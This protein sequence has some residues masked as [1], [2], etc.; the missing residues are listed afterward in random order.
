M[1][2]LVFIV[3]LTKVVG[4]SKFQVGYYSCRNIKRLQFTEPI[5]PDDGPWTNWKVSS[6]EGDL[7]CFQK[8]G[9]VPD[10]APMSDPREVYY[11]YDGEDIGEVGLVF[12]K[13]PFLVDFT[14][15]ILLLVLA[16]LQNFLWGWLSNSPEL[17]EGGR[18]TLHYSQ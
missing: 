12:G 11:D 15:Y 4:F 8:V 13:L 5:E 1:N 16:V 10:E 14:C 2:V 3:L 7:I 6:E 18:K 9:D 17:G